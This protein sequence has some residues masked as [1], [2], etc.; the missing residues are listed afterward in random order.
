MCAVTWCCSS[1]TTLLLFSQ[2]VERVVF[3]G[4]YL[5]NNELSMRMLAFAMEYWSQQTI[6]AL[7]LQHEGYFGALGSILLKLDSTPPVWDSPVPMIYIVDIQTKCY[8]NVLCLCNNHSMVCV[9]H[10]AP[11]CNI[12]CYTHCHYN[13]IITNYYT[14][15]STR[16]VLTNLASLDS[17]C[18]P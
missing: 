4:N 11:Y 9:C 6:R 10:C 7:F 8:N 14:L 17:K 12:T 16:H 2:G 1:H 15:V 3:V 5:C 13:I 18:L